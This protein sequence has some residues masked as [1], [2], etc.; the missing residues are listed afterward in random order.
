MDGI[1]INEQKMGE[2]EEIQTLGTKL[3]VSNS[4][5][6]LNIDDWKILRFKMIKF[7]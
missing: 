5:I 4:W 2:N 6:R 7:A 3:Q 1:R